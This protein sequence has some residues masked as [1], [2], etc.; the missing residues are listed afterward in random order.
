[1]T[2]N[3]WR[4]TFCLLKKRN[5]GKAVRCVTRVL[6]NFACLK[7]GIKAKHGGCGPQ[8]LDNFA[9]L[10]KGI[11]AKRDARRAPRHAHFACLKKGIKAKPDA[12]GCAPDQDFACLKKGIKVLVISKSF[13]FLA[14]FDDFEVFGVVGPVVVPADDNVA[15]LRRVA[16][17]AEFAA[18]VFEFDADALPDAGAG[19]GA[20]LRSRGKSAAIH[21]HPAIPKIFFCIFSLPFPPAASTTA[22]HE[23]NIL[24]RTRNQSPA[25]QPPN[26]RGKR[27]LP[28][29]QSESQS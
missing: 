2:D 14:E 10:K 28:Q 19:C 22:I 7:K 4:L 18:F 17:V 20:W 5:Q 24:H 21:N 1:M 15:T 9:C 16:V 13:H 6:S 27:C 26:C 8:G 23:P 11:K 29:S 3:Q 12:L 25:K